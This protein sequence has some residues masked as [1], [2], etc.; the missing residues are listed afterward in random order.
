MMLN[1]ID[2]KKIY[3]SYKI[4]VTAYTAYIDINRLQMN[5]DF[6]SYI[7][8]ISVKVKVIEEKSVHLTFLGSLYCPIL[9]LRTN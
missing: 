1:S 8:S 3:K 4:Y 2:C 5:F 9:L 7:Q 6:M